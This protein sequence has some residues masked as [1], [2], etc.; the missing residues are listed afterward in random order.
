VRISPKYLFFG[1]LT[2]GL[3][4]AVTVGGT[5]SEP[6][7]PGPAAATPDG[8]GRI[9]VAPERSTGTP[10]SLSPVEYAPQSPRRTYTPRYEPSIV[11]TTVAPARTTPSSAPPP[12]SSM[13]APPRWSPQP[14]PTRPKFPTPDPPAPS[15]T[16][17]D[18][19]AGES[20]D[21]ELP[22]DP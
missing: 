15:E 11:P 3:P 19:S 6:P 8:A 13:P 16:Q 18:D 9:G 5:V 1:L 4:V 12:T 7:P 2:V 17:S 20:P 22:T 21:P 14:I 10:Q